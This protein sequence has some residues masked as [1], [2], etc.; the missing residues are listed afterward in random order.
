MRSARMLRPGI[1]IAI[2]LIAVT[3]AVFWQVRSHEFIPYDDNQYVTE[4][5]HVLKG[6]TRKNIVWAFTTGHAGNWHPLTW[7]SHMLDAEIYG[8]DAGWHHLTSVF[9]HLTGA[10]LLLLALWTMTGAWWRSAFAAALFAIH[11]L[12]VESVAWVSERKDVLSALF[13][14]LAILAYVHHVRKPDEKKYTALLLCFAAGLMSKPMAVTLPFVLLLLDYW[15][16]GRFQSGESSFRKMV[17]EKIPLFV[18][19]ACSSVL[20][21]L[22]QDR[23]GSILP[24]EAIPLGARVAN[25]VNAYALYMIKTVWPGG[26]AVYYP[27]PQTIRWTGAA[28]AFL[29]LSVIT[30]LTVR[31]R[32]RHPFLLVGWLWYLGTLVPVIGLV[33]AGSQAMADRYTYVPLVGLFM[34]IAWI[35]PETAGR[36]RKCLSAAGALGLILIFSVLAFR[37][38]AFW[39]NGV[40]LFEHALRVTRENEVAHNTLGLSLAGQGFMDEAIHH[41][42]RAITLNPGYANPY[43]NLGNALESRGKTSEAMRWLEQAV[44]LFPDAGGLRYNLARLLFKSG[45]ADQAAEHLRAAVALDPENEKALCL[46]GIILSQEG[47]YDEAVGYFNRAVQANPGFAEGYYNLAIAFRHQNRNDEAVRYL[48]EALEIDPGFTAAEEEQRKAGAGDAERP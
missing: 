22:V 37:Q 17:A 39:K 16:L 23:A 38:T 33:Q 13:W 27:Y 41:Y 31:Y 48:R 8:R 32:R 46:T 45:R 30:W 47:R 19:A 44:R 35:V 4:N 24:L 5:I 10:L 21:F 34:M 18:L 6:F 43:L 26:L 7:L 11:P 15:P 9:L 2:G 28:G 25:A 42:R 12:H 1:I 36:N 40:T 20:T 3:V 29:L 14:F